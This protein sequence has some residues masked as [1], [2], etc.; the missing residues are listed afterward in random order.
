MTLHDFWDQIVDNFCSHLPTGYSDQVIWL[1]NVICRKR[2]IFKKIENIK[3]F[4]L[5]PR[6][7]GSYDKVTIDFF[8]ALFIVYKMT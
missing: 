5:W 6:Y 4:D 3:R 8:E 2:S 1:C 7:E